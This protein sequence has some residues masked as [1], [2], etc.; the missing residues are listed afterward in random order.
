ML[1]APIACF[2][3]SN[4][5][6]GR[7]PTS[8]GPG[9]LTS[10]SGSLLFI[11]RSGANFSYLLRVPPFVE[12]PLDCWPT[13][14]LPAAPAARL[15]GGA[16]VILTVVLF[17]SLCWGPSHC[18]SHKLWQLRLA[19][20][21]AR[22]ARVGSAVSLHSNGTRGLSLLPDLERYYESSV[23]DSIAAAIWFTGT[24][25]SLMLTLLLLMVLLF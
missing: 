8:I 12:C 11:K 4:I 3:W 25:K 7:A 1:R 20:T 18:S 5:D 22:R 2:V 14:Y 19:T 24:T 15:T 17:C 16:L 10:R 21:G 23:P 13:K 9:F 6:R